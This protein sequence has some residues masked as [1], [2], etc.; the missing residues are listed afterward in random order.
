MDG[1]SQWLTSDILEDLIIFGFAERAVK[2]TFRIQKNHQN[3]QAIT[4][5]ADHD[6]PTI[7]PV[8]AAYWIFLGAKRLGQADD[9]PMVI[10]VNNQGQTKYLTG[11]KIAELLQPLADMTPDEISRISSHSRRVWAVVLLDEAGKS[12]DFI[13]SWLRYMGDSYRFYLQDTAVIQHQHIKALKTNSDLIT[14]LLGPN[15]STLPDTVPID[16]DKLWYGNLQW[17]RPTWKWLLNNQLFIILFLHA[18]YT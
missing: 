4:I 9:H 5:T 13:K 6:H 12:P 1:E 18:C 17:Q 16:Y 3:G 15:H 11:S 2:I 14:K 8:W 7:C 10:F